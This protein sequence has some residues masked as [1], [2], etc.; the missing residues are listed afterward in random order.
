MIRAARPLDRL[1]GG[2]LWVALAVVLLPLAGMVWLAVRHLPAVWLAPR[3]LWPAIRGSLSVV[4]VG[5]ALAVPAG[6]CG[7]V[8]VAEVRQ[9]FLARAVRLSA[10]LLGGASGVVVGYAALFAL[11]HGFGWGFGTAAGGL[12]LAAV[13]LPQVVGATTEAV[14]AV[15]DALRD[16]S[17]ALGANRRTTVWRVVA[18][19]AAPRILAGVLGAASLGIGETAALACTLGWTGVPSAAGSYLTRAVWSSVRRPES[20]AAALAVLLLVVLALRA[21]ADRMGGRS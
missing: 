14:A 20:G 18:P 12:A 13:M 1:A 2:A 10:A 6:L 17:L 9:G 3:G 11:V 4:G 15:P 7:G 16:A 21:A 19:A 5:L 8:W